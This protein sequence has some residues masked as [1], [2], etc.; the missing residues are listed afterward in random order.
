MRKKSPK[1]ILKSLSITYVILAVLYLIGG[2]AFNLIPGFSEN[3]IKAAGDENAM[4]TLNA[5][6]IV[7]IIIYLWYFWLARRVAEGKSNGTLYLV[8]L[9]LGVVG[10]IIKIITASGTRGIG[11]LDFALNCVGLYYLLK[12]RKEN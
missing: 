7:D 5:G 6:I 1:E 3:L 4:I 8:L 10:G 11:T 9:I 12:V 2:I